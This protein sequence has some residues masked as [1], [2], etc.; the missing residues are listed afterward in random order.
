MALLRGT[1]Y[2]AASW[3][4]LD[5][6]AFGGFGLAFFPDFALAFAANSCLTFAAIWSV[7]TL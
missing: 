3:V 6:C 7:S 1:P 5:D 4:D 2:A